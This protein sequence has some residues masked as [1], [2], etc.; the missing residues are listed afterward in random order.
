MTMMGITG[1]ATSKYML[2]VIRLNDFDANVSLPSGSGDKWLSLKYKNGIV[3]HVHGRDYGLD[4]SCLRRPA[5]DRLFGINRLYNG[6]LGKNWY[7][8]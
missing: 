1:P 2:S 4:V 6:C 8:T 7:P 5:P 3:S